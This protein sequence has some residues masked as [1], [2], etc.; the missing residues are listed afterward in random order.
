MI[1]YVRDPE[2]IYAQSFAEISRVEQVASLPET[3]RDIA[4]RVIHACGMPDIVDDLRFSDDIAPAGRNALANG[5]DIYCD[6]ETLRHGIMTRLL[7]QG[8]ATHCRISAPE[9]ASHAKAHGMTRAAA[10]IDLW[11]DRLAGQIVAVGNVPPA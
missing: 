7:P 6:V 5:A 8:C 1:G 11:G 10:Q 9:T 4:I 2:A 3:V